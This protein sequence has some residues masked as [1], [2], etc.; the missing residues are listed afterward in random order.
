MALRFLT[1]KLKHWTRGTSVLLHN[2]TLAGAASLFC[3]IDKI[4]ACVTHIECYHESGHV[5]H[6]CAVFSLEASEVVMET[7]TEMT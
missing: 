6:Y 1:E 4:E 2:E 7:Q 5:V 3:G